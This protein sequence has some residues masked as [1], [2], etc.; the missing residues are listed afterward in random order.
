MDDILN[1]QTN[2]SF[3]KVGEFLLMNFSLTLSRY[4]T[5][6][7]RWSVNKKVLTKLLK[8]DKIFSE[9][10]GI[11]VYPVTKQNTGLTL[12][13]DTK[14][15][16]CNGVYFD[17]KK[18]SIKTFIES[19][20]NKKQNQKL[21]LTTEGYSFGC[22]TVSERRAGLASTVITTQ[23]G[24]ASP[25]P[26]LGAQLIKEIFDTFCFLAKRFLFKRS[27]KNPSRLQQDEA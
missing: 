5:L 15:K 21:P 20:Q 11:V 25:K 2:K 9:Y 17:G 13:N 4:I 10:I 6:I 7:Q 12:F 3:A 14:Q 27:K 16:L 19:R 24:S 18:N 22:E 26:S 1:R 8:Y 23:G